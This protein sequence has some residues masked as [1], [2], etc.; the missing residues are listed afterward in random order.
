MDKGFADIIQRMA[1]EQ[2]KEVLV[3]GK[4]KSYLSDYCEGRFKKEADVFLRILNAN[5]GELINNADNIPERKMKLMELLED[6]SSLSPKITTE[7]LDLLGLILKGNTGK[8]RQSPLSPPPLPNAEYEEKWYVSVNGTKEGPLNKAEVEAMLEAG[9]ITRKSYVW[10]KGMADWVK[11][12][13]VPE[14]EDSIASLPPPLPEE[15]AAV[16]P[17][18]VRINGGTFTMGSPAD[19]PECNGNEGPQ[20]QVTVSDFYMGKYQVTQMEYH[21]VMGTNPSYFKGDNLPVE[22]VSWYDA[23]EYCNKLSLKE[24]LT[25]A[26]TINK[27]QRDPNN[28]NVFDKKKWT[29]T[30]NRGANGYRL[31]TEAE[32]EYACRAGTTTAYNTGESISDNTGWY[33]NNSGR[34]THPVGQKPANTW[35]LYDMH[36]NIYEWCWDWYGSYSDAEQS[37]PAG[38]AAGEYRVNRGGSWYYSASYMRSAFRFYFN[39]LSRYYIFGFRLVHPLS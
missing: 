3:N 24:G 37:D 32:W 29:I 35:G 2:G 27:K 25:P 12:E 31:P 19:G 9:K 1:R 39:P 33:N 17:G 28:K 6:D 20:H 34:K 15:S 18:F 22:Q 7:Y 16:T 21:E 10:K 14:L 4:A 23:V 5:C 13:T 36:G 11:A 8:N 38:A 26:Y 30:W